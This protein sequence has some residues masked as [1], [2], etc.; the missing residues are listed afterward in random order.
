MHTHF[1]TSLN[2]PGF[3]ITLLLLPRENEP[4]PFSSEL[5]I[6]LLDQETDVPGWKWSPRSAPTASVTS[7]SSSVS[8]PHP[9]R[10]TTKL[11]S[12]DPQTFTTSIERA[13]KALIT[14]EPDITQ[15][16]I[17]AGDGDCGLTLKVCLLVFFP[18]SS[19]AHL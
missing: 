17:I 4:C 18:R 15:M 11:V 8:M 1:Q 6:S 12:T 13:C 7:T 16:D 5:L 3:S 19:A 2:M 9:Y 14:A 10:S